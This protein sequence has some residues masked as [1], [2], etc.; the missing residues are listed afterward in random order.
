[1]RRVF[2]GA[3]VLASILAARTAAAAPFV[4]S[5]GNPTAR[6]RWPPENGPKIE[7]EA[8]D[9][10]FLMAPKLTSARRSSACSWAPGRRQRST[11]FSDRHRPCDSCPD[12]RPSP[13]TRS[14]PATRG[15]RPSFTTAVLNLT[16][17]GSPVQ[18]NPPELATTLSNT[19][20]R[21]K[22]RSLRFSP[23]I[24]LHWQAR[25]IRDF[26]SSAPAIVPG[27]PVPLASLTFKPD[28]TETSPRTGRAFELR[29][30]RRA[31]NGT[32]SSGEELTFAHSLLRIFR[33]S[34]N[35]DDQGT[36]FVKNGV[37]GLRP[38]A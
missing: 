12:P 6:W 2:T 37:L 20:G 17:A 33:R 28:Q 34:K 10:F 19:A 31:P 1:M 4:F 25:R 32:F 13:T 35:S 7:I 29:H 14:L 30:C 26:Y 15:R 24:T 22:P 18:R 3:L 38:P 27:T 8:A 23:R 5:T 11:N 9:D 16:F 36:Q 21:F